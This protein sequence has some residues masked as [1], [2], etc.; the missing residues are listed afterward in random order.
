MA[1]HLPPSDLSTRTSAPDAYRYWGIALSRSHQA[2]SPRAEVL[3]DLTTRVV[4]RCTREVPRRWIVPFERPVTPALRRNSLLRCTQGKARH[5]TS[6]PSTLHHASIRPRL[7]SSSCWLSDS[8]STACHRRRTPFPL[9]S[10][11]DVDNDTSFAFWPRA[12][13]QLC[14]TPSLAGLM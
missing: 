6:W 14:Q 13:N 8:P 1:P 7:L 5:Y 2:I 10:A 11:D 4:T 3:H 12:A 9:P